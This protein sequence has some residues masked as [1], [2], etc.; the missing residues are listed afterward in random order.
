MEGFPPRPHEYPVTLEPEY[1]GVPL[2]KINNSF[3]P[4]ANLYI[5]NQS[6]YLY[7]L[8]NDRVGYYGDNSGYMGIHIF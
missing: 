5:A 1:L 8:M 4:V 7:L 3:F 6:G 2:G